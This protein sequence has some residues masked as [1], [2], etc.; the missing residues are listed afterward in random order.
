MSVDFPAPG[1]PAIQTIGCSRA[2][3]SRTNSRSRRSTSYRRGRLNFASVI[4]GDE[5]EERGIS[6][7]L[8]Q[9]C[10]APF[11]HATCHYLPC[12]RSDQVIVVAIASGAPHPCNRFHHL[13]D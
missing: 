12:P 6:L 1:G 13:F 5:T 2:A 7:F 11:R 9:N 3:S 8:T 10:S 4:G